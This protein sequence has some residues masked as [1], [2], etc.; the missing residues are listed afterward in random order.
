MKYNPKSWNYEKEWSGDEGNFFETLSW[1]FRWT[2]VAF[3]VVYFGGA[4]LV[5]LLVSLR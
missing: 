1:Q 4:L 3:A 2:L 5:P